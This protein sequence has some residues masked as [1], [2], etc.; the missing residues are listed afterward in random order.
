MLNEKS[1]TQLTYYQIHL[2]EMKSSK[3]FCIQQLVFL[4]KSSSS[5]ELKKKNYVLSTYHGK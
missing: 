2:Y 3:F 5:E 4:F 1:H